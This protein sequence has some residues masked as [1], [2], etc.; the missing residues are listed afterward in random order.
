MSAD[1]FYVKL[2]DG[3]VH[4]VSL[5][6]LD[7]AFQAG[8]IDG[9]TMVLADGSDKWTTLGALAGMDDEDDS[10]AVAPVQVI[11]Q[12]APAPAPYS[13]SQSYVPQQS[14]APQPVSRPAPAPQSWQAPQPWQAPVPSAMPRAAQVAPYSQA[15]RTPYGQT[16]S[17]APRAMVPNSVRPVSVDLG[18]DDLDFELARRGGGGKRAASVFAVLALVGAA[19]GIATVRPP[20][21][22]PL[23]NKIGLRG[24]SAP[25]V[26]VA[27]PPPPAAAELPPPAQEPTPPPAPPQPVAP[28]SNAAAGSESPLSPRFTDRSSPQPKDD[29]AKPDPKHASKGR[30]HVSQ[31][32]SHGSSAKAKS[33][34]VFTTG[35]NKY[36][37]L[38]SSI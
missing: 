8:H 20:F 25:V 13:H 7:D 22:R 15:P 26:A 2:A 32:A 36:D 28:A 34:G 4:R 23:L 24:P 12:N 17:M 6:Q 19:A 14:Y 9:A 18:D 35:G 5:D 11:P 27:A 31:P 38:N 3:D 1:L 30:V 10:E 37:P 21:A 33:N 16:V 29:P